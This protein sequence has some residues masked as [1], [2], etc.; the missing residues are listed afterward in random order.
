M[1][2]ILSSLGIFRY[3]CDSMG[4]SDIQN[5][6][7]DCRISLFSILNKHSSILTKFGF[8][9][10]I[11][12]QCAIII[13]ILWKVLTFQW[14]TSGFPICQ[15]ILILS[16]FL[17][18]R[19][20]ES[21]GF[22]VLGS[23]QALSWSNNFR[24]WCTVENRECLLD[25]ESFVS[26]S[27]VSIMIGLSVYP[28]LTPAQYLRTDVY[29]FTS[30][31]SL[32]NSDLTAEL[33]VFE[34]TPGTSFMNFICKFSVS[35]LISNILS[36]ALLKMCLLGNMNASQISLLYNSIGMSILSDDSSNNLGGAFLDLFTE[37]S[38]ENI[39]FRP[40]L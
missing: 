32:P 2:Q 8:Y 27:N 15:W 3:L 21:I 29:S 28:W 40:F 19:P 6:V 7:T 35:S 13:L 22:M 14:M 9:H 30:T 36:V 25:C 26:T 17:I 18:F 39:A 34:C 11:Q 5:L 20:K 12:I 33:H 31:D 1:S 4:S 16:L 38:K 24:I 23:S 37:D 10:F